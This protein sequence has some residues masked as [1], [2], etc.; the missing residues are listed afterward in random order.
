MTKR[1]LSLIIAVLLVLLLV[2]AFLAQQIGGVSIRLTE[3]D[4]APLTLTLPTVVTRGVST[5]V[6]VGGVEPQPVVVGEL[7]WETEVASAPVQTITLPAVSVNVTFPCAGPE[8]GRLLLRQLPDK[9]VLA[10][11]PV[12]LLAPGEDCALK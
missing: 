1:F 3:A 12:Q 5:T 2:G 7:V 8:T 9:R 10:T 4:L 6:R 11:V